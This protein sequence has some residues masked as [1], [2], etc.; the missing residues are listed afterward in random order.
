L[1]FSGS[2]DTIDRIFLNRNGFSV[3]IIEEKF[4]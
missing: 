4:Q 2:G 3:Y 1:E